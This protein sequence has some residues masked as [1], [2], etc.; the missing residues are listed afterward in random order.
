MIAFCVDWLMESVGPAAPMVALPATTAP[1]VGL[2]SNGAVWPKSKSSD[3]PHAEATRHFLNPS[4]PFPLF[5]K[6][7]R[8]MKRE[9]VDRSG[10]F[11]EHR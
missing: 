2:P 9:M 6:Q 4:P 3:M 10:Q 7:M 1:P 5:S 8:F 11:F